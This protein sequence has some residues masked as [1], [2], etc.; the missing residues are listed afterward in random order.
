MR[1]WQSQPF[2]LKLPNNAGKT[3]H[4]NCDLCF[5]KGA[6]QVFSLIR[7]NPDRALWWIEQENLIK[8]DGNGDGHLFRN[9]RPSY[10]AMYEMALS[11]GDMFDF[12]DIPL[13]DCACTD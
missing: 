2:D 7:E 10:R 9:D 8:P 5:L 12:I 1:F 3:M 13:E 4:G 11:Q 6:S